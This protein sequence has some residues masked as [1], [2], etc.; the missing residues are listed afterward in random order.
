VLDAPVDQA[1]W[2]VPT[3]NFPPPEPMPTETMLDPGMFN[4]PLPPPPPP[5]PPVDDAPLLVGAEPPG[6]RHGARAATRAAGKTKADRHGLS[7]WV[8]L[9]AV[10]CVGVIV[11]SLFKLVPSMGSKSAGSSPSSTQGVDVVPSDEGDSPEETTAAD[12]K[13]NNGKPKPVTSSTPSAASSPSPSA[14]TKSPSPKPSTTTATPKPSNT[15][16]PKPGTA[17]VSGCT[18]P[19]TATKC[20]VSITASGGKVT[21]KASATG[22]LTGSGAGTLA[23]G[24]SA[25]V[26]ISVN[27]GTPCVEGSGPVLFT[28]GG[29]ATVS[30]LCPVVEEPPGT[31]E[32]DPTIP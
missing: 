17:T 25:T 22:K 6:G 2:D 20:S 19:A 14:T 12:K 30:W 4:R 11:F 1:P 29:S 15:A 31:G 28:P 7:V 9:A 8:P 13:N 18:I 23:A 16:K 5:A 10:L 3:G 26:T 21:W 27:K 32:E 24:E